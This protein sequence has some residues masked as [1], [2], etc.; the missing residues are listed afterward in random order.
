M[1]SRLNS[2]LSAM[3]GT[4]WV[5]EHFNVEQRFE[6]LK[7]IPY[8]K[9]PDLNALI[10]VCNAFF[11]K[12]NTEYFSIQ[13]D[14][15]VIN[16]IPESYH[17]DHCVI[18]PYKDYMEPSRISY[19]RGGQNWPM[20]IKFYST[21]QM[22]SQ[23][24]A[25]FIKDDVG[26]EKKRLIQKLNTLDR[27]AEIKRKR[28][29]DSEKSQHDEKSEEDNRLENSLVHDLTVNNPNFQAWMNDWMKKDLQGKDKS[30]LS[31]II[32]VIEDLMKRD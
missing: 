21:D 26:D 27:S 1:L 23:L 2:R 24:C 29:G 14:R 11:G 9:L 25:D 8:T 19:T 30:I 7:G 18:F 17:A 12:D 31:K 3:L 20:E 5:D 15:I 28:D 32:R 10:N 22:I 6:I 13:A 16:K 4:C